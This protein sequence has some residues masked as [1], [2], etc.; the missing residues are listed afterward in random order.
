MIDYTL[1]VPYDIAMP[2]FH[3]ARWWGRPRFRNVLHY[4][5][6]HTSCVNRGTGFGSLYLPAC[7]LPWNTPNVRRE[8]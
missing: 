5:C 7:L 4:K 1:K 6:V 8:G 2:S 3:A